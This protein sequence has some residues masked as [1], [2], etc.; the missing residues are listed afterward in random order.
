[1]IL[2]VQI[3]IEA[4]MF[5]LFRKPYEQFFELNEWHGKTFEI[6]HDYE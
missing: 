6:T 2:K 1:M 5:I 3:E 4:A